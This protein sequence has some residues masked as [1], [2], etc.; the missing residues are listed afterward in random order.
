MKGSHYKPVAKRHFPHEERRRW[1]RFFSLAPSFSLCCSRAFK[2]SC[3]LPPS[4]RPSVC[5]VPPL[6][7]LARCDCPLGRAHSQ[8]KYSRRRPF[9]SPSL[10]HLFFVSPGNGKEEE[11]EVASRVQNE[12]ESSGRQSRTAAN[13]VKCLFLSHFHQK[14]ALYSKVGPI[15]RGI[16]SGN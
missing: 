4:S 8:G 11:E 5:H 9:P 7:P 14:G 13:L 3:C 2:Q 12:G 1:P 10:L 16:F 15:I 6:L